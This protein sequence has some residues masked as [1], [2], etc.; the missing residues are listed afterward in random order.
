V[1]LKAGPE[2]DPIVAMRGFTIF[3]SEIM[4]TVSG[5]KKYGSLVRNGAGKEFP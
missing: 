1:K 5:L 3:L 4:T 2:F